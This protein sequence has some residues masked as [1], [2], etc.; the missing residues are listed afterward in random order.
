MALT[1]SLGGNYLGSQT[2]EEVTGHPHPDPKSGALY[3]FAVKV[4][5]SMTGM[6]G[7]ACGVPEKLVAD[8]YRIWEGPEKLEADHYRI[9][10]ARSGEKELDLADR[11]AVIAAWDAAEELG[12]G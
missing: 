8:N 7:V 4:S 9:W 11:K 2:F 10:P 1:G 3:V 6:V 12:K 5:D